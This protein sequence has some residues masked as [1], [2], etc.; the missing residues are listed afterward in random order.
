M[1]FRFIYKPMKTLLFL[2]YLLAGAAGPL[3][4]REPDAIGAGLVFGNPPGVAAKLWY[5]SQALD[6][7]V[8]FGKDL[9]L[10]GDYLW[11]M[12]KVLPRASGGKIPVYM[13]VGLQV[14]PDEFGLRVVAGIAYWL[15]H[16]PLEI[17][18]DAVPVLRLTPGSSGGLGLSVGARYYF[19]GI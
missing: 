14:S 13:G 19:S 1:A 12:F 11:N 16:T 4:A 10:Y 2:V 6:G 8:I 3:S 18:C 15:P 5:G 7:G 17:F 9:T